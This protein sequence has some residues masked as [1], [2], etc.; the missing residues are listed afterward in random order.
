[1]AGVITCNDPGL[2]LTALLA[3]G[4]AAATRPTRHRWPSMEP[5][6]S[7]KRNWPW[8]T[9][10]IDIHELKLYNRPVALLPRVAVLCIVD[11]RPQR[12]AA[13][14]VCGPSGCLQSDGP[15]SALQPSGSRDSGSAR[16]VTVRTRTR[17]QPARD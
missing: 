11:P 14:T 7:R 3:L 12:A 1:M 17:A 8:R 2:A 4:L 5:Q 15:G 10:V 9:S 6:K 13:E 16:S